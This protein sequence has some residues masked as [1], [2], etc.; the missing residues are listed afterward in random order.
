MNSAMA[1]CLVWGTHTDAILE[2]LSQ[3]VIVDDEIASKYSL[4][5]LTRVLDDTH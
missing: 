4:L 3:W 5:S 2:E 1:I